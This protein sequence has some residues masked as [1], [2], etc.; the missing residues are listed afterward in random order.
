MPERQ[1][2]I[3][4]SEQRSRFCACAACPTPRRSGLRSFKRSTRINSMDNTIVRIGAAIGRIAEILLL[5]P[6]SRS[7]RSILTRWEWWH[8]L[9]TATAL[10]P[11]PKPKPKPTA[12]R[13][14]RAPNRLSSHRASGVAG[15][16]NKQ[17]SSRPDQSFDREFGLDPD[18]QDDLPK[19]PFTRYP[20]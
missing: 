2:R 11:K 13:P 1:A 20:T 7:P 12:P 8:R 14:T 9:R 19:T 6:L 5:E 4:P 18:E 15:L 10:L 3:V 17:Q 16:T